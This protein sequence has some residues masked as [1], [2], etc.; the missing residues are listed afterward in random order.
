MGVADVE[1][2]SPERVL[3]LFEPTPRGRIALRAA[4]EEIGA[5]GR[6]T[7]VALAPQSRPSR[8]C[9]PSVEA[10]NCAVRDA[11][12]RDL[13]E[14][15]EA[16]G[17]AA[18]RASFHRLVGLRDPSLAVWARRREF[19]LVVLPAHRLRL[20][21]HPWARGLRRALA[22]EIRVVR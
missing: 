16:L 1:A 17:P 2:L 4:A 14:A 9:G 22:A 5:D 6:L 13:H 7:V 3:V 20:R 18:D 21:G 15:R 10:L 11:A 12:E 19:D 8:C